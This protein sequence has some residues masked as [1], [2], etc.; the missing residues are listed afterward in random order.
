[1]TDKTRMRRISMC[2]NVEGFMRNNR[3]PRGYDVFEQDDG[4]PLKPN[5]ALAFLTLEKAK[6][7]AVIPMSKD[8]G[9]PCKHAESGCTGFDYSAGGGCPGHYVD[10]PVGSVGGGKET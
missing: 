4:T 9:A 1:M 2:L 6:G 7:R 3:F 10:A 5:E 8:C